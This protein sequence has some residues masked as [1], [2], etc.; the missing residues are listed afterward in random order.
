MWKDR[1]SVASDDQLP[2]PDLYIPHSSSVHRGQIFLADTREDTSRWSVWK[3]L[4]SLASDGRRPPYKPRVITCPQRVGFAPGYSWRNFYEHHISE[5]TSQW[6]QITDLPCWLLCSYVIQLS[7]VHRGPIRMFD[8]CEEIFSIIRQSVCLSPSHQSSIEGALGEWMLLKN[9]W[10]RL[11]GY[12]RPVH[13]LLL[14]VPCPP[15]SCYAKLTCFWTRSLVISLKCSEELWNRSS[16]RHAEKYWATLLAISYQSLTS[17]WIFSLIL[18]CFFGSE[19][20]CKINKILWWPDFRYRITRDNRWYDFWHQTSV[21][22]PLV[23]IV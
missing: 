12:Y 8:A 19:W 22:V 16:L 4:V 9:L 14:L 21:L 13:F 11:A 5:I 3:N 1:Y 7:I 15:Q 10:K 23:N 17:S 2:Q 20:E 18:C 6:R